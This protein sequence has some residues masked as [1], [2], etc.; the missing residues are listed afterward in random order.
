MIDRVVGDIGRIVTWKL[1]V[2]EG[3]HNGNMINSHTREVIFTQ[4]NNIYYISRIY[5]KM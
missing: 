2:N 5:P 4:Q 1:N 3:F